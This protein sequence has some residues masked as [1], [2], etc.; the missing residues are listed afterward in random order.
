MEELAAIMPS[1]TPAARA[2]FLKPLNDAMAEFGIDTPLRRAHF[3]GQIAF[4][5]G[6]LRYLQEQWGPTPAQQRYEPPNTLAKSLG[7]TEP[8]D[9]KRYLGRGMIQI[10]GRRNYRQVGEWLKVNLVD[11]PE[12]AAT[13]V[14]AARVAAVYW[15]KRGLNNLADAD[16]VA[17]ITR[18]INGGLLGLET[19]TRAVARAKSVLMPAA[20]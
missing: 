6:D 5:G 7:N 14:I 12:L 16:N 18:R 11:N 9:G 19:R 13:P 10:V 2:A 4:E 3:L 17:D 8:G 20:K 1:S 15:N